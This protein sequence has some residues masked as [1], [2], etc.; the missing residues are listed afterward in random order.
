M[1][2]DDWVLKAAGDVQLGDRLRLGSGTELTVTRIKTAFLG[3]EQLVC[4]IEDS[5]SQWL[6]QAVWVTSEVEIRP[7]MRRSTRPP[8][9]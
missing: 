6:A 2:P 1:T 8:A 5:E 4:L 7:A 3:H 9:V